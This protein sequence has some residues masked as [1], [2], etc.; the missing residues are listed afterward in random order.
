MRVAVALVGGPER[1]RA[2]LRESAEQQARARMAEPERWRLE[3]IEGR[4]ASFVRWAWPL[5]EPQ[6]LIWGRHM[7]I[8]CDELQ[9]I[10]ALYVARLRR[11]CRTP[12]EQRLAPDG[13]LLLNICI[14]PGYAKSMLCSVMLPAFLWIHAPWIRSMYVSAS[15]TPSLRDSQRTRDL[16]KH[17]DY[18]ALAN[19]AALR[20]GHAPW[21]IKVGEDQ[22]VNFHNS[23][24]GLRYTALMKGRSITGARCH[25]QVID[26]AID[27][28]EVV[29]GTA[30]QI[31]DRCR[32]AVN[33]ISV[34]L[35]TRMV[36][37][38]PFARVIVNQRLAGN[39]P[40]S[41]AISQ[42]WRST[43]LPV[44][45]N[46]D[47][48]AHHGG[49]HPLDDRAPGELLCP[50]LEPEARVRSLEEALGRHAA[51]QLHQTPAKLSGARMERIW[52]A[53]RYTVAPTAMAE[54]CQEIWISVDAAKKGKATSD[55]HAMHVWGFNG[56]LAILLGRRA[57]RWGYP[58]F[59]RA[60]DGLIAEWRPI[61]RRKLGGVRIED[62]ANG[63]TYMQCR[64]GQVVNMVGFNPSSDTPGADKSKAARFEYLIRRAE[65]RQI[66]LPA[67]NVMPDVEKVI[68][69]WLAFDGSESELDD[70]C[71]A[72]S[73][74]IM[75]QAIEWQGREQETAYWGWSDRS[76]R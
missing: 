14:P 75:R 16:V 33:T 30:Q 8:L 59:E 13:S 58:E 11:F 72:A 27:A 71:D 5:V 53:D 25:V 21:R 19:E 41:W 10:P 24:R 65:A 66:L 46:P 63:T 23:A 35:A 20:H 1:F 74:T 55:L 61:M 38:M 12:F 49:P 60:L 15:E 31:S 50:E 7:E 73:Q 3:A 9:A 22:N 69:Y 67:V 52:F 44:R 29:H 64:A 51:A 28:S 47:L 68:D 6:P 34:V 32:D 43:V 62:Q 57:G 40:S 56:T 4:F 45:Y 37:A 54:S 2:M 26:D 18:Q 42:G 36:K 17:D 48:P 76:T 70:D 39:D